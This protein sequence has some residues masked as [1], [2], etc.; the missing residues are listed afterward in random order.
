MVRRRHAEEQRASSSE[1]KVK[2]FVDGLLGKRIHYV[3]SPWMAAHRSRG[4]V[5]EQKLYDDYG[6]C[7]NQY[8]NSD[9]NRPW[10]RDR[11][12]SFRVTE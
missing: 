12:L 9:N 5:L 3:K 10:N 1:G 6:S 8:G 11:S 2:I 4:S 7:K